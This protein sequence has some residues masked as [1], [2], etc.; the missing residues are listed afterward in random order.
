MVG[1]RSARGHVKVRGAT[2]LGVLAA[3]VYLWTAPG[4][5]Q[6]PDD[7]IVF[8][9]AASLWDDGDLDIPGIARRTGEPQ[10]RPPGTFGWA[11]GPDGQRYGFF[12]HGLSLV[13]LPAYALASAT[14]PV[15]PTTWPHAVRSDHFVFHRREH[16]GDWTRLVV[17]L[18][19]CAITAATAWLLALWLRALGF[20]ARTALISGLAFAFATSAWAYSRT[21]LSEP[22]SGLC[23]LAAAYCATRRRAGDGVGWAWLGG[24]IAGF[25][26]HV[27]VLNL[28][29]VPCL[30]GLVVWPW[31]GDRRGALGWLVA[32]GLGGALLL[33]GQWL[34]FGDPLETGRFGHYSEFVA[35]WEG[36]V[37]QLV[38]PGRSFLLYSPALLLGLGGWAALRRRAPAAFWFALA[39]ISLRWLTISTRS[40]WFGGWGLGARHLVPVIPVAML[41]FAATLE[42]LPHWRPWARR[43]WWAALAL[44]VLLSCHLALHSIFEWMWQL[45]SD[46][47]VAGRGVMPVSHWAPW[48]S[49]IVGYF[50]LKPDVLALG[51]VLL[52][53]LGHPGLLAIFVGVALVGLAAGGRVCRAL[54]ARQGA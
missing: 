6:F 24:A 46:P 17:S 10:G 37:A 8:Q 38:A 18:S 33:L 15:V 42:R 3:A 41:G 47:R 28:V 12:G 2:A 52:A 34:R 27:H 7:E 22:L 19:N 48:A 30:F 9:T 16:R 53:R 21:F 13:A 45:L 11:P 25:S 50:N 35:P 4:R 31:R 5:I 20:A 51:A 49:P 54:L 1:A 44:G 40:D 32:C 26:L 36:L 14:A 39:A 43:T 23:L 29:F